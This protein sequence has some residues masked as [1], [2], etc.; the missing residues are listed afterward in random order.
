[1]E[2][3]GSSIDAKLRAVEVALVL[4]GRATVI[5]EG[6]PRVLTA[7]RTWLSDL[8]KRKINL[9]RLSETVL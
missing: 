6:S 3:T 9:I 1:L 7:L 5:A 8:R 4:E 2:A